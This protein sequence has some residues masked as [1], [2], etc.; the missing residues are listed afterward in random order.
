MANGLLCMKQQSIEIWLPVSQK[1]DKDN[2]EAN[3]K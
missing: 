3:I 2:I 1:T